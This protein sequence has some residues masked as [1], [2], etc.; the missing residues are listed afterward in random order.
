MKFFNMMV[1]AFVFSSVAHAD[2]NVPP[3]TYCFV[4]GA[5]I[6][7]HPELN[8]ACKAVR[9]GKVFQSQCGEG[10]CKAL[11]YKLA[12]FGGGSMAGNLKNFCDD[13]KNNIGTI[14]LD[15][16]FATIGKITCQP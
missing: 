1:I 2:V 15:T 12:S 11:G 8:D 7:G 10:Y 3:L 9:V 16:E 14:P 6:K 5:Q 13:K 4:Q